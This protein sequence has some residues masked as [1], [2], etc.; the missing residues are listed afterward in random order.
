[1]ITY[2][3]NPV[4]VNNV[5]ID[6]TPQEKYRFINEYVPIKGLLYKDK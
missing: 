3:K 4:K 5:S 2:N 6:T 1:M